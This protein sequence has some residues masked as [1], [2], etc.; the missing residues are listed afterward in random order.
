[1]K[2]RSILCLLA[3]AGLALAQPD[4]AGDWKGT[5]QIG[6]VS[7]RLVVH[8]SRSADGLHATLDSLD[9]AALGLP[10]ESIQ[11]SA[12][13]LRLE[14]PKLKAS[15]EGEW[16]AGAS[17]FRG[18]FKQ[19]G[20][21]T[22][23]ALVRAEPA[24]KAQPLSA[25]DRDFLLAHLQRTADRYRA[26]I[27]NLNAAQWT[28]REAPGKW[29]IAECAE[30]LVLAERDLLRVVAQQISKVPMPDG[31]AR[32]GRAEDEKVIAAMLDRSQKATAAESERPK[33]VFGS[34]AEAARAFE[35]ARAATLDYARSTQEDLRGHGMRDQKGAFTDAYQL[36]L[37]LSAHTARHVAQMEEVKAAGGY[38]K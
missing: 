2:S 24:G 17:A 19:M 9:Q 1:M 30:H 36:L 29:S 3:V 28:F 22:P 13:V 27:A 25:A 26:E 38:P 8:V 32:N 14:M 23:L 11:Y 33:G 15:Y 5:L 20:Q 10:V 37:T 21:T 18:Q 6:A 35:A 16:D 12:G 34:P 31:Q 7:L 4:V